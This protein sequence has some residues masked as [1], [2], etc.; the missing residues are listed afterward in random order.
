MSDWVAAHRI[1]WTLAAGCAVLAICLPVQASGFSSM[2]PIAV[3]ATFLV[4]VTGTTL[5][6]R[7][8]ARRNWQSQ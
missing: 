7:D 1:L 6:V 2:W 5:V 4:G 3:A 8:A